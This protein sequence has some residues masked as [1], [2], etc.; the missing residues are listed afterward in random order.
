MHSSNL[1][2][3]LCHYARLASCS[4][5]VYILL[6]WYNILAT[7]LPPLPPRSFFDPA[8]ALHERNQVNLN[9]HRIVS[10]ARAVERFSS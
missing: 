6:A 4:I 3:A 7:W 9:A 10:T 5:C 2:R 1:T 8:G